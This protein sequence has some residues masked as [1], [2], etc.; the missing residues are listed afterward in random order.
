MKKYPASKQISLVSVGLANKEELKIKD[1]TIEGSFFT[2]NN[3]Q[4]D[5]ALTN[6]KKNHKLKKQSLAQ[7]MLRSEIYNQK[8]F[9]KS[10]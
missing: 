5:R 9:V 6:K 7:S 8:I 1:E 3:C 10:L 2:Q 4:Y